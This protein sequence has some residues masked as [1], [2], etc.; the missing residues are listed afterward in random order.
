MC[1][2]SSPLP[3]YSLQAQ[4]LKPRRERPEKVEEWHR[5]SAKLRE[6]EEE[7]LGGGSSPTAGTQQGNIAG[8]TEKTG[9]GEE[10]YYGECCFDGL[11]GM[12]AVSY[13]H[14]T[15]PTRRTV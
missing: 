9:E 3:L 6:L 1:I 7:L 12:R 11:V 15:L 4:P 2:R 5:H 13:T 8:D 10:E 14:L